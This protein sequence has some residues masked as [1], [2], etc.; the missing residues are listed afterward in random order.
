M[1]SQVIN[2]KER[3]KNVRGARGG[4]GKRDVVRVLTRSRDLI[5]FVLA[6]Y[7]R[8]GW[9]WCGWWF[10]IRDAGCG[11]SS[12]VWYRVVVSV[13]PRWGTRLGEVQVVGPGW[14]T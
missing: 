3:K 1:N 5:G 8:V 9:V 2:G 13:W 6:G 7:G 11:V 12:G 14:W 4:A 10:A